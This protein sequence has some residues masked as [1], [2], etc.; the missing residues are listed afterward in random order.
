MPI[1]YIASIGQTAA[2][3]K[4]YWNDAREYFRYTES[5]VVCGKNLVENVTRFLDANANLI[6]IDHPFRGMEDYAKTVDSIVTQAVDLIVFYRKRGCDLDEI[7]V[8]TAGGTEKMSCIIKDAVDILKKIA[9]CVTH[10]WGSIHGYHTQYTVKTDISSDDI[11][12]KALY[13]LNKEKAPK[14]VL[15]PKMQ[16]ESVK[17]TVETLPVKHKRRKITIVDPETTVQREASAKRRQEQ[18]AEKRKQRKEARRERHL[19]RTQKPGTRFLNLI[20]DILGWK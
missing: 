17:D 10:V 19:R 12:D 3:K 14:R 1:L 9:P 6:V 20:K 16:E 15:S 2:T 13:L 11:L 4:Q 8:N 5:I 7:V 18:K